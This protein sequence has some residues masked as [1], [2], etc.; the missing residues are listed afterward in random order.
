MERDS[1]TFL[2]LFQFVILF[3]FAQSPLANTHLWPAGCTPGLE[4]LRGSKNY[5]Y[6]L[7]PRQCVLGYKRGET[8]T[9]LHRGAMGVMGH[10][11]LFPPVYKT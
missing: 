6:K 1:L 4:A 8:S 10:E 2:I 9:S 7:Q 3:P 5:Y 11:A